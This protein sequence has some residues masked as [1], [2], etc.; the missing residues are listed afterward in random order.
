M[1][2]SFQRIVMKYRDM[3]M[4]FWL[5]QAEAAL[6]QVGLHSRDESDPRE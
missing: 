2:M 5:A 6:T 1:P 4:D 3:D